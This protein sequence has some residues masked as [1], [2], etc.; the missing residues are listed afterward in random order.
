MLRPRSLPASGL[1]CSRANLS[2]VA[3]SIV[4]GSAYKTLSTTESGSSSLKAQL[5]ICT[6]NDQ[7]I[8]GETKSVPSV[9]VSPFGRHKC[10]LAPRAAFHVETVCFL[11]ARRFVQSLER[12]IRL[13]QRCRCYFVA[14][15]ESDRESR[16]ALHT[17]IRVSQ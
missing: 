12:L 17:R 13:A 8:P 6:V 3:S 4:G 11:R 7:I 16:H 2:T 1:N 5:V 10:G 15:P 14:D 9:I